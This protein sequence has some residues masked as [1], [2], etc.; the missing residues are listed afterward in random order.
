MSRWTGG[1]F[2]EIGIGRE[3]LII[4]FFKT[5]QEQQK[6]RRKFFKS[7][8]QFASLCENKNMYSLTVVCVQIEDIYSHI[9]YVHFHRNC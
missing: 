1:Q 3:N 6:G 7:L 5:Y 9:M 8:V 4:Q 2:R